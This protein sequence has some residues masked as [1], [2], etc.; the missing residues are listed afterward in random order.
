MY[1]L[2][3]EAT[4]RWVS[5]QTILNLQEDFK[6]YLVTAENH[7]LGEF[8][9]TIQKLYRMNLDKERIEAIKKEETDTK[10]SI[11][12][13]CIDGGLHFLTQPQDIHRA[14]M[15]KS[16]ELERNNALRADKVH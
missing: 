11:T 1:R 7:A 8:H 10:N 9:N 12:E 3:L 13:V 2:Y 5:S 14:S 15:Q 6:K 4:T 16:E